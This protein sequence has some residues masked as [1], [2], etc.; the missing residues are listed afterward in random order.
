MEMNPR[1]KRLGKEWGSAIFWAFIAWLFIRSFMFEAFSIPSASMRSTLLEGDYVVVNKLS[2]GARIPITPLSVPMTHQR[3]YLDWIQL[4]YMRIP[5]FSDI[6]HNDVVVFN[7]PMETEFPVDHRT[8]YIKRCIGLPGDTLELDSAQVYINGKVAENP[9]GMQYVYSV[10]TDTVGIDSNFVAAMGM[11]W[12][13]YTP[14]HGHYYLFM[15]PA[16]AD[17]LKTLPHISSVVLNVMQE[18][19]YDPNIFPYD[20]NLKWNMDNYGPLVIPKEGDS[21]KI[22]PANISLYKRIITVYE[23]NKITMRNDSVFINDT[24][25]PWYT[26]QM[27]Y[28]FMMG[29]NRHHSEDSRFWGFVPEDHIVGRASFIL[30]SSNEEPIGTKKARWWTW[31]K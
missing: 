16:V 29:D 19:A 23:E 22:T 31:I 7:Y 13:P 2:Y 3:A 25:K 30:F 10:I 18:D 26:F 8:H 17:S 5:G 1:I 9:A 28:Y 20:P 12:A 27:N 24:F 21:V 15:A 6:K 14:M 4:P 11:E